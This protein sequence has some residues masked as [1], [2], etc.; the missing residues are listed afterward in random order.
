MSCKN[1]YIWTIPGQICKLFVFGTMPGQIC[2]L[3]VYEKI[4]AVQTIFPI[5]LY[6]NWEIIS[7]TPKITAFSLENK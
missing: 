5:N 4:C 3:F 2:K 1:V 6:G 7:Y